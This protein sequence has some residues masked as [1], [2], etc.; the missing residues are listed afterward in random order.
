MIHLAKVAVALLSFCALCPIAY[1]NNLPVV[2]LDR[3]Y[4]AS[5]L[6]EFIFYTRETQPE[7][8]I[9]F[10]GENL[11]RFQ[12]LS[13]GDPFYEHVPEPLLIVFAANNP[14][15]NSKTW[16]L[17][18]NRHTGKNVRFL[19][20]TASGERVLADFSNLNARK[21]T[22][23]RRF[24][25]YS[26]PIAFEPN[27]TKYIAIEAMF[28]NYG[29]VRVELQSERTFFDQYHRR[30]LVTV[31]ISTSF[32]VVVLA[33]ILL[34]TAL[35]QFHFFWV[36][37]AELSILYNY[38]HSS[39]LIYAMG[40]YVFEDIQYFGIQ[41]SVWLTGV[42]FILFWRSLLNT[43][44]EKPKL[45]LISLS[46]LV[47]CSV[48]IC[49]WSINSILSLNWDRALFAMNWVGVL[50]IGLSM[51]FLALMA[52]QRFGSIYWPVFAGV[53]GYA[54]LSVLMFV[55][56]EVIPQAGFQAP[57]AYG[58]T[59]LIGGL[60]ITVFL[61]LNAY[62]EQ[63]H[64]AQSN[65]DRLRLSEEKALA[66][67]TIRDQNAFLYASGH[68]TRQVM[69]A[70]NNATHF[71]EGREDPK[72]RELIGTLKTSASFLSDILT[73]TVSAQSTLLESG[74]SVALGVFDVQ[75]LMADLERLY[76]PLFRRQH[77][78]LE[79]RIPE[80][81][82]V[83]SDRALLMRVLSNIMVNALQHTKSGG[84]SCN[85]EAQSDQVVIFLRDSGLGIDEKQLT[86]ITEPTG[87]SSG[88]RIAQSILDQL[89][90]Q[91]L[92]TSQLSEGTTVEVR[93]PKRLQN[94]SKVSI[95]H[96]SKLTGQFIFDGDEGEISNA[97]AVGICATSD[98]HSQFRAK[99][100]EQFKL[101]LYK[102]LIEE[103]ASHP[104]VKN[105][106]SKRTDS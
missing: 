28:K 103:M 91:L 105:L 1:S 70:I 31:G 72:D 4:T 22:T 25:S 43:K 79:T 65:A 8:S 98:R 92:I 96:L 29:D 64:L 19:E 9:E 71:L 36:S 76:G 62:R 35:R 7:L 49:L 86:A 37:V 30:S 42:G 39:G 3:D 63:K 99:A 60:L 53:T 34:F 5:E 68:D 61:S 93:L 85:V 11:D 20:L 46:L 2:S 16:F 15:S 38:V 88:L 77:L 78:S 89:G 57:T 52:I 67:T 102:P 106:A 54:A 75:D 100:S 24:F 23:P 95:E 66:D 74:S 81:V 27:E 69:L 44:S 14:S 6:S 45:E 51:P 48:G 32:L 41:V 101:I 13:P 55:A 47:A 18:T 33:N 87:P 56:V 50:L 90:G 84:L 40:L 12:R 104:S 97:T 58:L 73:T 10:F 80:R 17:T 82:S 83:L 26:T 21:S 94:Q 59:G